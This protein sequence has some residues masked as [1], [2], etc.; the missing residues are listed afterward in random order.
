MVIET[1]D[2][3]ALERVYYLPPENSGLENNWK[4][5]SESQELFADLCQRGHTMIANRI[6]EGR[7]NGQMPTIEEL[8]QIAA[9]T[10][11]AIAALNQKGKEDY[12]LYGHPLTTS[13]TITTR[14]AVEEKPGTR[15]AEYFSAA[16]KSFLH[17]KELIETGKFQEEFG[18]SYNATIEQETEKIYIYDTY[19][20]IRIATIERIQKENHKEI[21]LAHTSLGDQA[22]LFSEMNEHFQK[23]GEVYEDPKK[24]WKELAH[25]HLG[26]FRAPPVRLGSQ[27]S[28]LMVL[29]GIAKAMGYEV[30]PKEL[31]MDHFMEAEFTPYKAAKEHFADK[32]IRPPVHGALPAES[33]AVDI[34]FLEEAAKA[35]QSE[36]TGNNLA[37]ITQYFQARNLDIR[38]LEIEIKGN[39]ITKLI[40]SPPEKQ[41]LVEHAIKFI[42]PEELIEVLQLEQGHLIRRGSAS[43]GSPNQG[44]G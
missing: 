42:G 36:Y 9:K 7:K 28:T 21:G 43:R 13:W 12:E 15:Y 4:N 3:L 40:V 11:R 24:F 10:R 20:N 14:D 6:I 35:M 26:L 31:N 29:A 34:S 23:I 32:F 25:I 22:K 8:Y 5:V 17:I 33:F 2:S 27:P 1:P 39:N 19:H 18:I 30:L 38:A 16:E 37:K 44:L 41:G